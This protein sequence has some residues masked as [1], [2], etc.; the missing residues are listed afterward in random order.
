MP[1]CAWERQRTGGEIGVGTATDHGC[2]AGEIAYRRKGRLRYRAF[3]DDL[4]CAAVRKNRALMCAG[5]KGHIE[6]ERRTER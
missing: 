3:T 4:A 6:G 2:I 1:V 5:D